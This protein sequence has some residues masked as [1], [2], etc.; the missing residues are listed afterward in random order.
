MLGALYLSSSCSGVNIAVKSLIPM[1]PMCNSWISFVVV[2]CFFIHRATGAQRRD[3]DKTKL[4]K[5]AL[6][7]CLD[8]SVT[9]NRV[10]MR[11]KFGRAAHLVYSISLNITSN[12]VLS[13]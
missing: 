11:K 4:G 5:G 2:C 7:F 1:R 3:A 13:R 8:F 10:F 6:R 12:F 9:P